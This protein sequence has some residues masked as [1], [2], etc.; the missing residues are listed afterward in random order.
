MRQ[1]FHLSS[2]RIVQPLFQPI[3]YNLINSFGL[4]ISLRVGRGGIPICNSQATTISSEGF[5]I[6]LK[7]IVQDE[8][9]RDPKSNNNVLLDELLGIHIPYV[10]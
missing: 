5:A 4:S 2:L 8:G 9:M 6:K 7:A 10:S 1:F 3:D